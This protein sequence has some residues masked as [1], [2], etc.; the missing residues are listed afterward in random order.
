MPRK[1]A[2]GVFLVGGEGF[3]DP[4]DCLCYGLDLGAPVL[5]DCGAFPGSWT[6]IRKN[7]RQVGLAADQLHSLVLTHAH[8][9]HAGAAAR[10]VA[11]TGC[12]VV[13]H[14]LDADTLE[15]GDRLRSAADWYQTELA[16]VRVDQKIQGEGESLA[17]PGGVLHLVHTPG[18]TPGSMCAWLEVDEGGTRQRVLFGQDVHGPF[19]PAFGS[20][21]EAHRAS[22]RKLLALEADVLCEGHLGVFHGQD[23]VREFIEGYL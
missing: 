2:P 9:D 22:L 6:A 21:R 16:P 17:F 15:R 12:R 7:L 5:I 14:A 10:V 3:S 1:I 13:A 23:A 19:H 18:H 8:I 20:D 4:S 11:E